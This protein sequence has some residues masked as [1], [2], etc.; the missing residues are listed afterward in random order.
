L[1]D[2][3]EFLSLDQRFRGIRIELA[4]GEHLSIHADRGQLQQV[5]L[6]LLHNAADAMPDGGVIT[7]ETRIE[8]AE[9][10]ADGARPANLLILVSD[11]GVGIE[12]EAL[13]NLFEPFWTSKAS[14]TGLGLA[15]VYRIMEGH[16][17]TIR[18]TRLEEGGTRFTITLPLLEEFKG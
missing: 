5:L 10:G 11:Q 18:A 12:D 17:G 8:A 16:G 6:N 1:S 3:C 14:G 4:V 13:R 2:L 9:N 15:T 7:I